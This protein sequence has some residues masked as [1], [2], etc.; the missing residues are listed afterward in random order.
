MKILIVTVAILLC[1]ISTA[2]YNV[3]AFQ[4][5]YEEI[6]NYNSIAIETMGWLNWEKEFE[7]SFRFPYFD[8]TFNSLLI[9][10]EGLGILENEIDYSLRLMAFGYMFDNVLDTINIES[11]VRYKY[12]EKDGKSY[13]V[14]QF[15]KNRLFSDT[16][17]EEFDSH[18][19][20]QYWFFDDGTIELRFGPSNLENSPI[21]V[22]GE[23]FYLIT[24]QGPIPAGP[25]LALYHPYDENIRLE[26]NDL[27][28]HEAY[29]LNIDGTGSVDWWPPEGWVIR[30]NN[31]LISSNDN[32]KINRIK[33]YPNPTSGILHIDTKENISKVEIY[34]ID[35]NI[36]DVYH[37]TSIDMSGFPNGF[38]YIKI[39]ANQSLFNHKIFKN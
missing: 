1:K 11:D 25:Q 2:Q 24:D 30:F 21:Y 28:S 36:L 4:D 38:Y 39:F 9:N 22:P 6:E 29:E 5:R 32:Q 16:S 20:F 34:N 19:N 12:G 8:T 7:L 26:Y 17:V 15:T 10:V 35:G 18:V 3:I 23:G 14:I 31:L 27:D 33:C 13:L 37:N